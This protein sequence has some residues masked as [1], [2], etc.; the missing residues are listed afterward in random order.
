MLY[1]RGFY[2]ELTLACARQRSKHA[3]RA[4]DYGSLSCGRG[5]ERQRL[6]G[7]Q[8]TRRAL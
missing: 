2:R 3:R 4:E 5:A 8:Y 7:H 1:E 6:H